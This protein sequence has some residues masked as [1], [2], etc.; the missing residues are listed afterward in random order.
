MKN[1]I[2]ILVLVLLFSVIS[3]KKPS[4]QI[5]GTKET[6]LQMRQ[7]QTR[8]FDTKDKKK[9]IRTIVQ[10][11][12]DLGFV[13]D[14]ADYELGSVSATKLDG[15]QIRMTATTTQKGKKKLQVRVNAQ[16][17]KRLIED[18][19]PYQDFFVALEKSMF[20]TAHEID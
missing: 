13:I 11:M 16:Y 17:N 3:C 4:E 10:T 9:T 1:F 8:E 18:P 15:Y 7:I 14:K 5:L 19:K 20:L 6:Q 2:N 12:Q